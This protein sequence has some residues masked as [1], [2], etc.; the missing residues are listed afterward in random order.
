MLLFISLLVCVIA[1]DIDAM[2]FIF[3]III[4]IIRLVVLFFIIGISCNGV[5]SC[6][7]FICRVIVLIFILVIVSRLRLSFLIIIGLTSLCLCEFLRF[8]YLL[9]SLLPEF[10]PLFSISTYQPTLSYPQHPTT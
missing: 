1:I 3:C 8:G 4:R 6:R 10:I 7:I 2:L 9:H 5:V